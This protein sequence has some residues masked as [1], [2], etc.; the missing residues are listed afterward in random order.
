MAAPQILPSNTE[1]A[2]LRFNGWTYAKIALF[3][4][5]SEQAVYM[6]LRKAN[7]TK[8]TPGFK[9][10]I[11]W[12]VKKEHD[13]APPNQMLRLLGRLER[14]DVLLPVKQ[15]S[16]NLWLADLKEA[17]VVVCYNPDQP[18]NPASP[19]SGGFYYSR[20]R[21]EDGE[22]LIRVDEGAELRV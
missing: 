10:L 19:K 21:P 7:L 3:Y 2:K 6:R 15:R 22:S 8:K 11:P 20:R 16:L 14:G 1:L 18:P 13:H 17:D 12:R 9:D 5:V 4:G